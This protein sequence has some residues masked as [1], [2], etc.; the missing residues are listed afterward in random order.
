[1]ATPKLVDFC[2]SARRHLADAELL[3]ANS[4]L[5]N[6]GHLYGYVAECGLKALLIGHGYPTD[7]EGSPKPATPNLRV[8]INRL[9]IPGTLQTLRVYVTG[10]SGAKY[11]AMISSIE[12]FSDWRVEHRYYSEK[13]LPQSLSKW[14]AAAREVGLMLDQAKTYGLL[15]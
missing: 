9:L 4:R 11:L 1:M 5:P 2:A 14:K 3:E 6:A 8:H 7:D 10:R 15:S 13:A 12:D